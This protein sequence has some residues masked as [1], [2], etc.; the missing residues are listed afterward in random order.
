MFVVY[1]IFLEKDMKFERVKEF[2]TLHEANEFL[3]EHKDDEDLYTIMM[4]P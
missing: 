4:E 3:E 1:K 2:N